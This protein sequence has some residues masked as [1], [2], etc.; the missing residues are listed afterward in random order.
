[1]LRDLNEIK[2]YEVIRTNLE[3]VWSIKPTPE[4][5]KVLARVYDAKGD[6]P[7]TIDY[8]QKAYD[9][10][11]D[12][13]SARSLAVLSLMGKAKEEITKDL[14]ATVA[15]RYAEWWTLLDKKPED[16]TQDKTYQHW[17]NVI[18]NLLAQ[19]GTEVPIEQVE[20]K[21]NELLEAA[22]ARLGLQSPTPTQSQ[23]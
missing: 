5:A 11:K 3:E 21:K 7:K 8:F 4:V 20:A 17:M 16:P 14:L 23:S 13:D 12:A 18:A 2:A 15:D 22:K 10:K 1:L 6:R 19:E 9:L